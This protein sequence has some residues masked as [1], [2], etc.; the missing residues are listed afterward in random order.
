M[1]ILRSGDRGDQQQSTGGR[2][3][4]MIKHKI[5]EHKSLQYFCPAPRPRTSPHVLVKYDYAIMMEPFQRA[6][7]VRGENI[8]RVSLLRTFSIHLSSYHYWRFV[9]GCQYFRALCTSA[10]ASY[11][12]W[13]GC[14]TGSKV[15]EIWPLNWVVLQPNSMWIVVN[16]FF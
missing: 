14:R 11:V 10:G 16:Y 5:S 2:L 12:V 6:S 15:R 13:I 4:A 7:E 8:K 9:R 1:T 3:T